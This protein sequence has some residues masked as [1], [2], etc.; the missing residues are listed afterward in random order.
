MTLIVMIIILI[1]MIRYYDNLVQVRS[2]WRTGQIGE[3][4]RD[5]DFYRQVAIDLSVADQKNGYDEK[6]E[7][8]LRHA[9]VG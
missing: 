6:N 9:T 5:G 7:D 3:K 4:A 2:G 1:L 8:I